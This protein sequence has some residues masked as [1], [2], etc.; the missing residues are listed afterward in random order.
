[1]RLKEKLHSL[2]MK[3]EHKKTDSNLYKLACEIEEFSSEH[4]KRI[5]QT[6]TEFDLHDASHSQKVIENIELI[7]GADKI[8]TL[9]SHEAFFLFV[10][11]YLHDCAMAPAE[12]ELNLMAITEGT[13]IFYDKEDS[14]KNDLKPSYKY[15]DAISLLSERWSD[16]KININWLFCPDSEA[17]LKKELAL[18]FIEYQN[19]RNGFKN[20]IDK[21]STKDEFSKLNDILRIDFIRRNHHIRIER[22]VKNMA[23]YFGKVMNQP[24]W[25]KKISSDLAIICR[26]HGEGFD[27]LSKI[28][29]KAHYID[30]Q[31]VNLQFVAMM[32][33]LGDIIHYS[34]DR[35]PV[36]FY[37]GKVFESDY[38]FHEWAIK[39]NGIN[40]DIHHGRISFKAYCSN[41]NDY[42]RLHKYIDYIDQEIQN[43]FILSRRWNK[44][45]KIF[46]EEKVDRT[47]ISND[48]DIFLPVRGLS[49]KLNQK[50]IIEL[51]MGVGLYKD[52][53]AC[54]RELY[55]NALDA[56]RTLKSSMFNNGDRKNFKIEFGIEDI[57]GKKSI[58]CY[59]NGIGMDRD[60]IESYL[61]NI[62]N[63]YYKSSRF[64]REQ[65]N[66]SGDFMPTS[67]F[68]IGIL[69]CFMLGNR[70]DIT[71]KKI[72][73][74]LI[75]CS[76]EGPH[77]NFYY[78]NPDILDKELIHESGT[79]I[80][81]LLSDEEEREIKNFSVENHYLNNILHNRLDSLENVPKKLYENIIPSPEW[82]HH[83]VFKLN[84]YI[85][86]TF[87]DF[88][89]TVKLENSKYI[90]IDNEPYVI[91][92]R[93]LGLDDHIELLDSIYN[94][95][96]EVHNEFNYSRC[97][98]SIRHYVVSST[99][100]GTSFSCIVFFPSKNSVI[101]D[102]SQLLKVPTVGKRYISVDG[103]NTNEK[104]V[105][106]LDKNL[107][108]LYMIGGVNFTGKK[109][110]Q[111]SV[112]RNSIIS[113]PSELEEQAKELVSKTIYATLDKLSEHIKNESIEINSTEFYTSIDY[114][115][116][117]FSSFNRVLIPIFLS[118]EFGGSNWIELSSILNRDMSIRDFFES[119]EI[120]MIHPNKINISLVTRSIIYS[121]LDSA[122][123]I[124]VS[125]NSVRIISDDVNKQGTELFI[126]E[127]D[128]DIEHYKALFVSDDWGVVN[129]DYD[130]VTSALPIIP[131]KLFDVITS[132]Y[133]KRNK[134]SVF[135]NN[136][137][138]GIGA[139]FDQDPLLVHHKM[140]LFSK[141]TGFF[142][143]KPNSSNVYNFTKK[144]SAFHLTEINSFSTKNE[145]SHICLY[146]YISPTPLLDIDETK[147]REYMDE[148]DY[149]N[150]IRNGWSILITG[151]TECNTIIKAGIHNREDL[152]KLIPSR[153]WD[154]YSEY[155]FKFCDGTI[156]KNTEGNDY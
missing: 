141:E 10:S 129:D 148:H 19:H 119:K 39:N 108:K 109:R 107:G 31:P 9:N 122:K 150:G 84:N 136:F 144:R 77:E 30:T 105:L 35:A 46:L 68:G 23:T 8:K 40:Y 59:D 33:R 94:S 146:V 98:K 70:I 26:A 41:P 78:R 79:I 15:S 99:H 112:D 92:Y 133:H 147:L 52:K 48:E 152:V 72:G 128:G 22:Y 137:S 132:D 116:S 32:L 28:D 4:L 126:Y 86:S 130:I 115:F 38:S 111:L 142:N 154:S 123:K 3:K 12:W 114:I 153:F 43:Y 156:L 62:G 7:L 64:Y 50:Q 124:I 34:Y 27:F 74:D 106:S 83:I 44:E 58:Y 97:L 1:M 61:L 47:G 110:P 90:K 82:K 140:G 21:I 101:R 143:R 118:S 121:K 42:F 66:C 67:Q 93:D 14:I 53:Y 37:Q 17:E 155:E 113:L 145:N 100:E 80:R 65:A 117:L 134:S 73:S 56:C 76:I 120:E 138:N 29:S 54:L 2:I 55:Q 81:V 60:I 75:S 25:G 85:A 36:S 5:F 95:R 96:D 69:S 11:A 57:N 89:V 20:D 87:V 139:F 16:I 102:V 127:Y 6:L 24:A 135:I 88:P 151:M 49:F 149:I 18:L 104:K 125:E 71:T 63:S 13:D 103:I 91:D 131:R 45:Y 51:L